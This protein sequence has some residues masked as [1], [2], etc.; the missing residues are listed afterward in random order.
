[1]S[2]YCNHK[3]SCVAKVCKNVEGENLMI[4]GLRKMV[5]SENVIMYCLYLHALFKEQMQYEVEL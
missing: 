4:K 1:V 2:Q 5:E 3:S